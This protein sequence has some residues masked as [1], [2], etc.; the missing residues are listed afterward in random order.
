MLI[1]MYGENKMKYYISKLISKLR[2]SSIKNSEINKKSK[3]GS[4][5]NIINLKMDKYSYIGNDC[6]IVNVEIGS[7]CSIANNC[8]IG[9]ANHP[10]DWLSTSPI[11]YEGKNILKKNFSFHK[12]N[13]YLNTHIGNDVWIGNNV[14]I[15]SGVKVSDGAIIGMGSIVTKNV[16]SYEIWAGNPA[17]F[18]RRRFP[19]Y[20][21]DELNNH[22]WWNYDEEKIAELSLYSQDINQM[23][24]K[25]RERND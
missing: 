21:I 12:Y 18:I 10:T 9:G 7:F 4:G 5:N 2:L 25:M 13:S 3:I 11:F 19:D 23:L 14:L 20:V 17:R 24:N 16:G 1:K 15:K 22:K 6:I 8:V